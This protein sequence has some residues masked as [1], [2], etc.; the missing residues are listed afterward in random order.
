MKVSG[1]AGE[2][3]LP[4][5]S[6]QTNNIQI[7]RMKYPSVVKSYKYGQVYPLGFFGPKVSFFFNI[8]KY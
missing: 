2:K 8:S 4:S 5:F 3:A 7:Y 6:Y 1:N